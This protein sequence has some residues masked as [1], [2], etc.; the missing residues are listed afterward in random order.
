MRKE[1]NL[2]EVSVDNFAILLQVAER[3]KEKGV[4]EVALMTDRSRL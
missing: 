4:R 3:E 2:R 1:L